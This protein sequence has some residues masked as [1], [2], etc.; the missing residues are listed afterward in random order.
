MIFAS[1]TTAEHTP[2]PQKRS[3]TLRLAKLANPRNGR[4]FTLAQIR[5][6][7]MIN[8]QADKTTKVKVALNVSDIT[9]IVLNSLEFPEESIKSIVFATSAGPT[10]SDQ[11]D[12]I[13]TANFEEEVSDENY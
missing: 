3:S 7:W 9:K 1:V 11:L 12:M 2:A 13:I 8:F 5:R 10:C 4:R 6:K